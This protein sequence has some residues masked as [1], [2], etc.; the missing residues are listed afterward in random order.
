MVMLFLMIVF[1]SIPLQARRQAYMDTLK[2]E[3]NQKL[4]KMKE[5]QHHQVFKDHI[6]IWLWYWIML[7]SL[8]TEIFIYMK[9]LKAKQNTTGV[10]NGE[11]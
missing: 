6:S 11:M 8:R 9:I 4:Q 2:E 1:F 5:E 10:K 7:K 3:Q